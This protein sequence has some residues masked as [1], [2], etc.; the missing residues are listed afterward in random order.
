[1]RICVG[2]VGDVSLAF[3][4]QAHRPEFASPSHPREERESIALGSGISSG[5]WQ[6]L[7]IS[8]GPVLVVN[9]ISAFWEP[10]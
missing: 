7:A 4:S 3:E 5:S 9:R 10:M 6:R 8:S 2:V 1:M